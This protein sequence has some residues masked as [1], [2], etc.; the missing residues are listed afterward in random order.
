M[1]TD[2][3]DVPE[4][5]QLGFLEHMS[6]LVRRVAA[7]GLVTAVGLGIGI[8]VPQLGL[9]LLAAAADRL[10]VGERVLCGVFFAICVL[11]CVLVANLKAYVWPGLY[12]QERRVW[13]LPVLWVLT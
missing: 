10:T 12:P 9:R 8:A 6:E 11:H 1:T 13:I 7:V 2:P 5:D 4:S 3:P